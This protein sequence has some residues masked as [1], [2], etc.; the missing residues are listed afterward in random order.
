MRDF[1]NQFS[2]NNTSKSPVPLRPHLIIVSYLDKGNEEFPV[3]EILSNL[4]CF[5][6]EFL[7]QDSRLSKL[8]FKVPLFEI[9][10]KRNRTPDDKK[11]DDKNN[12]DSEYKNNDWEDNS[13]EH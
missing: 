11:D 5:Q 6:N 9:L 10:T 2:L 7:S 12:I 8:L 13:D 3:A 1:I 4:L